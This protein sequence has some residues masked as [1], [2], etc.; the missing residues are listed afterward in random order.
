MPFCPGRALTLERAHNRGGATPPT[1]AEVSGALRAR[2]RI[3]H[4]PRADR[5]KFVRIACLMSDGLLGAAM[6]LSR[7]FVTRGFHPRLMGRG[8][9]PGATAVDH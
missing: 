6:G 8:R 9:A 1:S 5:A 4:E 7:A 3:V 2:L